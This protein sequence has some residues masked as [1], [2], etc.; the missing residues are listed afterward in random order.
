MSKIRY[1]GVSAVQIETKGKKIVIDPYLRKSPIKPVDPHDVAAD[2]I[3]V[4]HGARDH[5]GDAIEL[6]KITGAT[7]VAGIDVLTVAR[8]NGVPEAKTLS[9]VPGAQRTVM[10]V[11]IKA[12]HVTHISFT[13]CKGDLVYT[14]VPMAYLVTLEEG[15]KLYHN[16]DSSLHGDFKMFGEIYQPDL[17]IIPIGMFPGAMTEMDPWEAAI[18]TDWLNVSLAMPCHYD[19][20][21]QKDWPAW[22]VEEVHKRNP[23]IDVFVMDAGIDYEIYRNEGGRP[24]I[25]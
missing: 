21:G 8:K 13:R 4:T 7:L 19:P 15:F 22:Y 9:M 11:D 1:Y 20:D 10:G 25:R 6:A 12:L 16:G 3:L 14:G 2:I 18:A 23:A 17:G 5:F 24:A